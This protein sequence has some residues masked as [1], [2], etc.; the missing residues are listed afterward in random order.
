MS[1]QA[2]LLLLPHLRE[3]IK[4][5]KEVYRPDHVA[6]VERNTVSMTEQPALTKRF[7][8]PIVSLIRA[9]IPFL[10]IHPHLFE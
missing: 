6:Q 10:S 8:K 7:S 2:F 1:A 3:V 9:T 4:K 5:K